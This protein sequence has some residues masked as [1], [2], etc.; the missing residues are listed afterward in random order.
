MIRS[1]V[2]SAAGVVVAA[3]RR[4]AWIS[5][6]VVDVIVL[7]HDCSVSSNAR[8]GASECRVLA[9]SDDVVAVGLGCLFRLLNQIK[10]SFNTTAN[11]PQMRDV[12]EHVM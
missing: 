5:V 11:R 7:D 2:C 8:T 9:A 12:K 6:D 10:C 4:C 3:G 1:V